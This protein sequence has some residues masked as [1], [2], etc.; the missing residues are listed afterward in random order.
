MEIYGDGITNVSALTETLA[1]EYDLSFQVP[2]QESVDDVIQQA[3]ETL[4]LSPIYL[5]SLLRNNRDYLERNY[6]L[7]TSVQTIF[8][9]GHLPLKGGI[10]LSVQLALDSQKD[11]FFYD[12]NSSTWFRSVYPNAT[13]H[14]WPYLP[15]LDH[16][17]AILGSLS[18]GYFTMNEIRQLFH[19]T[20][21]QDI[22]TMFK[23]L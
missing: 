10:G 1:K 3:N 12:I 11:V 5:Q 6:G 19:R 9:F 20:F 22:V 7:I 4:Q 21:M 15:S 13:F 23:D 2:R 18:V 16:H 8:A 17:G 14:V